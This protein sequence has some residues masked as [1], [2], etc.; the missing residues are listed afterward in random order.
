LVQDTFAAVWESRES[1]NGDSTFRTWLNSIAVN[2]G[3]NHQRR[4]SRWPELVME[5]DLDRE[6]ESGDLESSWI[7]ANVTDCDDPAL[8]YE[9]E[10]TALPVH[11]EALVVM[12]AEG[13]TQEEIAEASGFTQ[14]Y[15]SQQLAIARAL[16]EGE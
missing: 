7:E 4:L 2:V 6:H 3:R 14:G 9:A 15:V 11:L 16:M 1:F 5:S 12:V 8:I 10:S 13:H